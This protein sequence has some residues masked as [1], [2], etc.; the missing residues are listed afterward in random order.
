MDYD[1]TKV[2]QPQSQKHEEFS[3]APP[4]LPNTTL[5]S[6]LDRHSSGPDNDNLLPFEFSLTVHQVLGYFMP[7]VSKKGHEEDRIWF[8]GLVDRSTGQVISATIWRI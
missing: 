4:L 7:V 2:S 8:K 3:A 6:T 5:K 1:V